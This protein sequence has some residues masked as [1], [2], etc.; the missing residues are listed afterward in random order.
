MRS[1]SGDMNSST[2][3]F[4][5]FIVKN[6]ETLAETLGSEL[7]KLM[8]NKALINKQSPLWACRET[9]GKRGPRKNGLY[10]ACQL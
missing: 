6:K 4:V 10:A 9:R 2:D 8:I 5:C 1:R 7:G 3:I